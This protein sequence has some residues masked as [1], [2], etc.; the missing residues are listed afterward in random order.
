MRIAVLFVVCVTCAACTD[1][2]DSW[3]YADM[4]YPRDVGAT[5]PDVDNS[6]TTYAERYDVRTERLAFVGAPVADLNGI[7]TLNLSLD[8]DEPILLL[9]RFEGLGAE[10]G[11]PELTYAP[12]VKAGDAELAFSDRVNPVTAPLDLDLESGEFEATFARIRFVA[13]IEYEGTTNRV[14][15]PI[16]DVTVAG[17]LALSSD[18]QTADVPVGT[19]RG[20]VSKAEG[21]VTMV[22]FAQGQPPRPLT[23]LFRE[24]TLNYDIAGGEEVDAGEGDAWLVR[25]NFEASSAIIR[26]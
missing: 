25:A 18:G 23:E 3:D 13:T 17:V 5:L 20:H 15:I 6:G 9:Y 2:N 26:D 12:G 4:N 22:T 8:L 1:N 21:D 16:S 14:D 19:W 7:I 10:A 24:E 11:S